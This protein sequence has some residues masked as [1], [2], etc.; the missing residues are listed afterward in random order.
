MLKNTIVA[1]TTVLLV[2]GTL[3]A[4][5]LNTK[6]VSAK[7][8][9][10]MH[11]DMERVQ[12]TQLGAKL[13]ASA[14]KQAKSITGFKAILDKYNFDF[15][16]D[17]K[18]MT[19]YGMSVPKKSP[20]AV[21]TDVAVLCYTTFNPAPLLKDVKA[22][23]GYTEVKHGRYTII[24]IP[25][26]DATGKMTLATGGKGCA[27]FCKGMILAGETPDAVKSGLDVLCGATSGIKA[28]TPG[29]EWLGKNTNG[30]FY[31]AANKLSDNA[32]GQEKP[33]GGATGGGAQP[34]SMCFLLDE[35]AGPAGD[36]NMVKGELLAAMKT[37][38]EAAQAQ[39]MAQMLL[40]MASMGLQGESNKPGMTPEMKKALLQ[41]MAGLTFGTQG[42]ELKVSLNVP[43]T[44][45]MLLA[46]EG[47]KALP[48]AMMGMA[49]Q[50]VN[51]AAKPGR[52]VTVE[53]GT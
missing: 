19:L 22:L 31:L 34:Q 1:A 14:D 17:V 15:K 18:G 45:V 21:P 11:V 44:T 51:G 47:V 42:A 41:L 24:P 16:R 50:P 6:T 35:V 12:A 43:T 32:A 33:A 39:M 38:Q 5:P 27:C 29:T 23:P 2:G 4:A 8:Q 3:T 10:V 49:G 52:N 40:G 53:P 30:A 20:T 46:D 28:G 48:G 37:P 13:L 25:D 9:W 36:G 26:V 7:A